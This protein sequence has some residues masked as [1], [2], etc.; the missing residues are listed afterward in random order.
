MK[1]T[2]NFSLALKITRKLFIL[3][4][5]FIGIVNCAQAQT[6]TI[7][8]GHCGAQGDN[9][10]WVFTN[11]GILTIS[12]SGDM[13]DYEYW[14]YP[15]GSEDTPWHDY[16]QQITQLVIKE[17]VTSIGNAAFSK[18]IHFANSL[19]I[20]NSV[21]RIGDVAFAYCS[22][23]TGS[24][25]LPNSV[26][27]IGCYAFAYC[28]GFNGILSIPNSVT[29][30]EHS[31][32]YYCTGFTGDLTIPN[33]IKTI[34]F[35]T[36]IYCSGF[37]GILSI[38]NSITH[39]ESYSFA[40]CTG[41]TGNLIIPNSVVRIGEGA[42]SYCFNAFTGDLIIPDFV[43]EIGI[44]AF[45]YCTGFTGS[46]TIPNSVKSI[47]NGAFWN[48]SGLTGDLIIPN[49]TRIGDYTFAGC[50]NLTGDLIIPNTVTYIGP[51]AFDGCTGFIG[52]LI[53]PNS[54]A[55]I[56]P[57]AFDGCTGFSALTIP[58][59]VTTIGENAFRNCS[60]LTSVTN[61]NLM[62]I[63]INENVFEN[64]YITVATLKVAT[65]AVLAYKNANVWKHFIIE[66]IGYVVN[67]NSNN[68]GYG[69][70]TGAGL[71]EENTDA[72]VTAIPFNGYKFLN[73]TKDGEIVS[74][75]NTYSFT[76]TEDIELV[77]NFAV[78]GQ[79]IATSKT[80]N[81][82]VYPNP[83]NGELRI[84]NLPRWR[85]Q[86]VDELRIENVKIYDVFGRNIILHSP[87]S[88]LNSIDISHFP[89]GVYFILI[90]TENGVV[91]KK[92]IKN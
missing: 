74:I 8:Q 79:G 46:L 32:F 38:P 78:N 56:G 73:W 60:G 83:T 34:R 30:I 82:S 35:N 22:G 64:V 69:Y 44:S 10:T 7:A 81:I 92:I 86:G 17:G 61:L 62:P 66:G 84:T 11:D 45:H 31:A 90:Q 85:G 24:L 36:F 49:I 39:I 19:V 75:E 5:I 9:L 42:F 57:G 63:A 26:K 3:I 76:V 77:A 40:Y 4:F 65:S 15:L 41:F 28:T 52:T 71:Y 48:C 53:I 68:N 18:C 2:L 1:P 58:H 59:S 87:F 25:I 80:A 51:N 14:E 37:K 27:T 21:T 89:S 20:P 50:K 13:E 43:T 91:T 47:G 70:A 55:S 6:D 23:F 12:G 16:I 72:T 67:L 33:S 54:T 29:D 88:I